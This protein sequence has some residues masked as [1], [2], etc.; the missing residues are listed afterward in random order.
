MHRAKA[1]QKVTPCL[2]AVLSSSVVASIGLFVIYGGLT[3]LGAT[4]CNLPEMLGPDM[5][6]TKLLVAITKALFGNGG[7]ILLGVIVLFACL[8]TAIGLS[9]S[10][11]A[12]FEELSGG[13]V[14][15]KK[16]VIIVVAFS[17]L[18][19]NAGVSTIIK[20]SAPL[21]MLVYPGVLVLIIMAFFHNK[22]KNKNIYRVATY[23][24]I[25][26]SA[27]EILAGFGLPTGFV[28]SL[29]LAPMGFAWIVPAIVGGI[30]GK[31][32]P[33]KD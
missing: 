32:I 30:I 1:T 31:F 26:V 14:S 23:F 33:C 17:W 22:I 6:Q 4:T 11:G 7:V 15:Y 27:L 29:P 5:N 21:L 3:Y 9:S 20:F 16:V 18:I 10:T 25:I 12:F 24:A 8:T 28:K 19:S 2:K 13:K